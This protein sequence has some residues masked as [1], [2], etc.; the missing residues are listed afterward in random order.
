MKRIL[1]IDGNSILN[2]AFYGIRP[3]SNRDGLP[4]SAIYGMT[5][6]ILS[7]LDTLHPDYAA[8]AF[9]L[10]AP[11]FRHIK[12]DGYKATRH[13]MPDDL[14]AQLPYAH[15]MA[16]ALGLRVV[17][18]AG[19]E[20]D[21]LLG[22]MANFA[23][24][25]EETAYILTGDR[26][27]LQLI[28][29]QIHVL[30]VGTGE[31]VE[32][33]AAKFYEKYHVRPDQ[34]V[35]VKALMGDSSDNIPGVQGIGS[36]TAEKLIGA[37]GS[38]ENLY[39]ALQTD[40]DSATIPVGAS[41]CKKLR[42]G[43]ESAKLS[44]FL[45]RI[46]TKVPIGITLEDLRYTGPNYTQLIP[47]LEKLEFHKLLVRFRQESSEAPSGA[48]S[49]APLFPNY[50]SAEESEVQEALT[51]LKS[52]R[53]DADKPYVTLASDGTHCALK[54][55]DNRFLCD[56]TP[57]LLRLLC[58]S[59]C[60]LCVWDAKSLYAEADRAGIRR[61]QTVFDVMLAAYVIH[62]GDGTPTLSKIA[63]TY[64]PADHP[65]PETLPMQAE[66]LAE[67][68]TVCTQML[69]TGALWDVYEKIELPLTRVLADMEET[70]FAIDRAG[71]E[72]FGKQLGEAAEARAEMIY[73]YA[74][75]PFNIQSPKQLGEVLF[76]TLG[77]PA[78]K[79]TK[80]GWSTAADVLEKL[81][82]YHPI[83]EIILEY[84][85]LTKLK[86]TYADGLLKAADE[87]GR[88]HTSFQQAV[89]ATGRLSSTEPNLQNIPIRTELGRE[90]RRFF[91][92]GGPDYVLVDADY[93]QIEL[94]LL[95]HMSGDECMIE[96]F[97]SGQDI[98]TFTAAQV[99][100]VS[101]EAV[102]PEMRKRAKAVNFG[103]VY[104]ISDFSLA[105][106]LGIS[107]R[108]A[109]DYIRSYFDRYPR[110][111]VYMKEAV[112]QARATGMSVTLFGRQRQIPELHAAKAT[113]RAFGERVAMNSPIQGTAADLMKIAMLRASDALKASG[114]DARLILQV[115]DE[116]I[117]EAHRSCAQQA[118]DMLKQAMEGA[119]ELSVPLT[120]D[121]TIGETWYK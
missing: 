81:R 74:G 13:G 107:R 78:P 14:A 84:R 75:M 12:Y 24:E 44:Q 83:I 28:A 45:A 114:I 30:L 52:D 35:D 112:E 96:A 102:T 60:P 57:N 47:L 94:R 65:R 85:Q 71:L 25:G 58:Q 115:H 7:H 105:G 111:E 113:L 104:G 22:T 72:R 53:Q 10:R 61:P 59:D 21:D 68:Q 6:T 1:L 76:D 2:R 109:A 98:H 110:I 82:F 4:T 118:A 40:S 95:A 86:S 101:P 49:P 116:L 89:T 67:L 87:T 88:I 27:S 103:I 23:Q 31:T 29:P 48:P 66:T 11:T 46:D 15:D 50:R 90:F 54:I 5:A 9:D 33:D 19:F 79:K 41:L 56:A 121:L 69:G 100:G 70:G 77:L 63:Q 64:L 62:P 42:D 117:V 38:L 119:A 16:Q 3:L 93:S 51:A 18:Q 97:R 73:S 120:V 8:V 37:C 92:P 55:G 26:D 99:F 17:E 39:R 80:T 43:E 106:D 108:Q 91:L 20:A 36:K 34:F 32:Y